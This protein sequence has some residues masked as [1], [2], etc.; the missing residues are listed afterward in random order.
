MAPA[1]LEG[2]DTYSFSN[3]YPEQPDTYSFFEQVSRTTR[4]V[5]FFRTGIQNTWIRIL[6]KQVSRIST[7]V[8]KWIRLRSFHVISSRIVLVPKTNSG[9]PRIQ[10]YTILLRIRAFLPFLP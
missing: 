5:F 9:Y 1:I 8:Q 3:R 7:R 4:Y 10:K 6:F 2:Y